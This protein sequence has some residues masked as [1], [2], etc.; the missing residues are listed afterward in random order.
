MEIKNSIVFLYYKKGVFYEK[1]RTNKTR[2][3]RNKRQN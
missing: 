2:V 1:I 3:K